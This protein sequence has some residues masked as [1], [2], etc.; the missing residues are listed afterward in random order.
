LGIADPQP[1]Y[2]RFRCRGLCLRAQQID[3]RYISGLKL[4]PRQR[5]GLP[6]G[7]G[8]ALCYRYLGL[9][10]TQVRII[11]GYVTDQR[12][13]CCPRLFIC[14]FNI[15]IGCFHATLVAAEKIE[16]PLGFEPHGRLV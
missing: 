12:D 14:G 11:G 10:A 4:A 9:R 8:V 16:F 2:L 15:V 3:L 1:R 5:H 6:L 13:E 7:C